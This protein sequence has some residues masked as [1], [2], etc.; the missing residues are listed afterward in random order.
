[1]EFCNKTKKDIH[2]KLR[3]MTGIK[4]SVTVRPGK[5]VKLDNWEFVEI[6]EAK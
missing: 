5:Y 1:M 2:L 3:K 6:V 4:G